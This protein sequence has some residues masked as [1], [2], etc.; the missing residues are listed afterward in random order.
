[1]A[2]AL[3]TTIS[4]VIEKENTTKI[5][6][7]AA[8][9][10]TAAAINATRSAAS[11]VVNATLG[12]PVNS[13]KVANAFTGASQSTQQFMAAAA[14]YLYAPLQIF[15]NNAPPCIFASVPVEA[16]PP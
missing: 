4:T 8:G 9:N 2:Y 14:I 16:G 13:S 1:M 7:S 15:I 10:L 3:N 6:S 5:V 12:K 11:A